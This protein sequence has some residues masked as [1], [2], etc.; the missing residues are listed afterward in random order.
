MKIDNEREKK[1]RSRNALFS[2]FTEASKMFIFYPLKAAQILK[3]D[4]I[5]KTFK[6]IFISL[7]VP[8]TRLIYFFVC[9]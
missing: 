8:L 4:L 9:F 5:E 3:T 6:K 7:P 1:S 2:V